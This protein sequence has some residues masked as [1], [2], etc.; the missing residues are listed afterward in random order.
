M[1]VRRGVEH[2]IGPVP[3][4]HVEDHVAVANVG[5]HLHRR[6]VE[7]RRGVVEMGLVVVEEHEPCGLELRDLPRDLRADRTGAGD[8]DRATAEQR[9]H[10][11]EV[12]D[13]LLA[14]EQVLDPQV[15]HVL[16]RRL[17]GDL[18]LYAG[19]HLERNASSFG[20]S[21]DASRRARCRRR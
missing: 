19:E 12:G 11:L 14:T 15:A 20:A 13:H 5:E 7:P 1:L 2:D 16:D 8:Q 3:A 9:A 17:A 18:V 6:R 10:G 21:G 4:E